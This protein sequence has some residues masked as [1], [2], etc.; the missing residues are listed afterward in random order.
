[1]TRMQ[2]AYIVSSW[3]PSSNSTYVSWLV[4]NSWSRKFVFFTRLL[5]RGYIY[6][7]DTLV[8][9]ERREAK[10]RR[11]GRKLKYGRMFRILLRFES[12]GGARFQ[13]FSTSDKKFLFIFPPR[14]TRAVYLDFY[15]ESARLIRASL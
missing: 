10:E 1:M 11:R 9:Y 15:K 2:H 3:F 13:R 8:N 6:E 14:L 12:G 5:F 7:S 4:S